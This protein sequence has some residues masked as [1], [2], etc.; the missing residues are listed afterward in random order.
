MRAK[1]QQIW[2]PLEEFTEQA[3]TLF[4]QD[5][6]TINLNYERNNKAVACYTLN[7]LLKLNKSLFY[8]R[9]LTPEI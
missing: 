9:Q 8:L 6:A 4:K 3:Q 5:L 7:K 1:E 2:I